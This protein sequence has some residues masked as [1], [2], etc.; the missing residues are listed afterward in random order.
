MSEMARNALLLCPASGGL[1]VDNSK[2]IFIYQRCKALKTFDILQDIL[3]QDL[4][5]YLKIASMF[6]SLICQFVF[7]LNKL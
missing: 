1:I 4:V 5:I 6:C 7:I 2:I 3:I